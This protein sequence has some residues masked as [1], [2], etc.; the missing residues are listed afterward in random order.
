PSRS[1]SSGLRSGCRR[2]A[3]RMVVRTLAPRARTT[4][5]RSPS[6][7]RSLTPSI[8]SR[9]I[10][11]FATSVWASEL[12]RGLVGW[13]A[14][15]GLLPAPAA[16]ADGDRGGSV[17]PEACRASY[18]DVQADRRR[19]ALIMA[20]QRATACVNACPA[21]LAADCGRWLTQIEEAI[22]SL[23]PSAVDDG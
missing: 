11:S 7:A 12:R 16:R 14:A 20:R 9:R 17:D 6:I 21:Q 4:L 1:R 22:P 10:A 3:R 23:V 5:R 15:A 19:S 13:L 18:A 2:R 8:R